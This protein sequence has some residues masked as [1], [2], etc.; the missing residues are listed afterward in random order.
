MS[1]FEQWLNLPAAKIDQSAIDAAK[2]HQSQLTKPAGSLGQLESIAI[3]LAG[4]QATA[5]PQASQVHISI[6]AADHGVVAEG[7]SAFPQAGTAEMIRNFSSGGAAISVLAK[8]L[9]A[10]LEVINMGTVNKLEN[11]LGVKD[12]RIAAGTKNF[13]QQAAMSI[14]QCQQAI[15]VGRNNVEQ[16]QQ[17]GIDLF[18][19]GEMGIGNTTSA[20][21]LA[22]ALLKLEV[23][24]L[25]GPGTGL[26]AEGVSHK[27]TIIEQALIKHRDDLTSPLS[28]L[29]HL[30]GF[31]IAALTGCYLACGKQ[32]LA[33]IIDGFISSVAAL[34]AESICPGTKHWFIYS[35]NSAE[36][37][38]QHIF[39][40]LG[41]KPII[42]IA[43]RLGEASGAAT[44]LPLIR[45]S[46]ALH[47]KM[48]TF[49]QAAVSE[50][51][52]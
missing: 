41:A 34:L 42:D 10:T 44:V 19:A 26:N 33:V 37:G 47:N 24:T 23:Q 22:A 5:R 2:Q 39:K 50:K 9:N 11:V 36:P 40:S 51:A 1:E 8:E 3:Q 14:E 15:L 35:H 18:I 29:Q 25:S 38:H 17:T 30:G 52:V 12:Q 28:I 48:A 45:L 13:K 32:G 49:E 43:M 21:A 16:V 27:T 6:F 20:T 4:M 46:C 7:I 31:E